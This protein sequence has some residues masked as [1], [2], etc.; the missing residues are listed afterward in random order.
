MS[1]WTTLLTTKEPGDL[2]PE[3]WKRLRAIAADIHSF[4]TE[5]NESTGSKAGRLLT[6]LGFSSFEDMQKQHRSSF[7]DI[8]LV[9]EVNREA[10]R[11]GQSINKFCENGGITR[12][13]GTY[14]HGQSLR[15][16]Y[17][18]RVLPRLNIKPEDVNAIFT[19]WM[20]GT[21]IEKYK[22]NL[23]AQQRVKISKPKS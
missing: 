6:I 17:Y 5:K 10:L 3:D 16:E 22:D 9:I 20:D 8:H 12:Y 1:I 15:N 2:A 23:K 14:L 21:T 18:N 11:K 4:A 7:A 19:D 13:D